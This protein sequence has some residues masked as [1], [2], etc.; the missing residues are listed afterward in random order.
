MSSPTIALHAGVA[1]VLLCLGLLSAIS[2]AAGNPTETDADAGERLMLSGR[3]PEAVTAFRRALVA[4]PDSAPL[5]ARL[6]RAL[7]EDEDLDGAVRAYERTVALAPADADSRTRL[8]IILTRLDRFE[9]ALA[10]LE[11]A[12]ELVPDH[13]WAYDVLG[14]LHFREG[15]YNDAAAAYRRATE[16]DADYGEAWFDLGQTLLRQT[17]LEGAES[18]FGKAVAA[19]S[20]DARFHDALGFVH[21]KRRDYQAA[22]GRLVRAAQLNPLYARAHFNLG[23]T[24]LRLGRRDEGSAELE[25]FRLLDD[26]ERRIR[27]L[28]NTILK[29]PERAELYHDMAVIFGQRGEFGQRRA[30]AVH[31]VHA[32]HDDPGQARAT[33]GTPRPDRILE[34]ADVIV[35]YRPD[36]CPAQPHA[37][38]RA[39]VDQRVMQDDIA[40]LRQGRQRRHVGP[41]FGIV[42]A[43]QPRSTRSHRHAAVER[44]GYG[45][46]H[47]RRLGDAEI[48]V[49][50]EVVPRPSPQPAQSSGAIESGQIVA[51]EVQHRAALA[52]RPPRSS[53]RRRGWSCGAAIR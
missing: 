22:A 25:T 7:A 52:T 29:P 10:N 53:P 48:V 46:P 16:A 40:A 27:S 44:C 31:A 9:E 49:R 32:L 5:H 38:M 8:A 50:G 14:K 23:N 51:V 20:S 2:G 41:M 28:K 6:A 47:P 21:Y 26:Q 35:R 18:A 1:G 30:V 17:D 45:V 39:G 33:I 15:R 34:C 3:Y 42:A 12:V 24:Y 4:V 37:V 43:Q 11:I 13:A 36:G 19:D